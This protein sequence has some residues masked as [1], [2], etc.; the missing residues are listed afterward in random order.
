[1]LATLK[2]TSQKILLTIVALIA[3][4]FL[5]MFD[6]STLLPLNLITMWQILVIGSWLDNFI[7]LDITVLFLV[8]SFVYFLVYASITYLCICILLNL[9]I[10][11]ETVTTFSKEVAS[12][13]SNIIKP[14]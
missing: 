14:K 13:L 7:N 1:M 3:L 4:Y 12:E 11:K 10:K 8:A 6:F 2:P 5:V 9:K